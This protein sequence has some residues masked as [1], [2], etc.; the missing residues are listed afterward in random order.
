MDEL[1]YCK[2]IEQLKQELIDN[3]YY[4]E[5]SKSFTH[6]NSLTPI[7]KNDLGASLSLVRNN[8]LNLD[9]F[10]SLQSLGTYEEMFANVASHDLYKSVYPY[11]IPISYLDENNLIVEYY[12]P[13]RLGEFA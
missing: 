9:D 2:N 3:G 7:K 6:G 13:Q 12:L 10:S 8:K 1:I 4:D 5:E 11:H